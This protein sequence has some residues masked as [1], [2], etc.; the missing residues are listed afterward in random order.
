MAE[1][2]GCD[3]ERRSRGE[4]RDDRFREN[5]R[6]ETKSKHSEKEEKAPT[7]EREGHH[8][9]NVAVEVDS[10]I[11][12]IDGVSRHHANCSELGEGR[13]TD[14]ART[15]ANLTACPQKAIDNRRNETTVETVLGRKA[16]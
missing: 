16:R 15:D 14:C 12:E 4:G 10:G 11:N 2:A 7:D 9:A 6:N 13:P 1:L 8:G 3:I 5:G